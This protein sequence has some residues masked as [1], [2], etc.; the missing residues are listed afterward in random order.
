[1]VIFCSGLLN[2]FANPVICFIFSLCTTNPLQCFHSRLSSSS[3]LQLTE[4]QRPGRMFR[5]WLY[6]WFI[7]F[8]T[9]INM[10]NVSVTFKSLRL[11][12]SLNIELSVIHSIFIIKSETSTTADRNPAQRCA[13]T[14][15]CWPLSPSCGQSE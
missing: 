3:V 15:A 8:I 7:I 13:A 9:F 5:W 2:C 1:M 14:A 12:W 10:L 4:N 11:K 6:E